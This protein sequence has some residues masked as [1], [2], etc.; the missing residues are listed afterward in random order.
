MFLTQL[1]TSCLAMGK[2]HQVF[3]CYCFSAY[4]LF[5]CLSKIIHGLS[6]D[7]AIDSVQRKGVPASVG[8]GIEDRTC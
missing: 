2:S 7:E 8:L 6:T 3:F 4:L 5:Y 1:V